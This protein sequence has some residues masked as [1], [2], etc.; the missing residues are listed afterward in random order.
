LTG[1]TGPLPGALAE[2]VNNNGTNNNIFLIIV[3]I[4]TSF[5]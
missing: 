4:F 2:N 1:K 3:F 5:F